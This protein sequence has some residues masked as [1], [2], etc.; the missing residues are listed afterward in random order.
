[1]LKLKNLLNYLVNLNAATFG[2]LCVETALAVSRSL[3]SFAATFGWLCVETNDK[4]LLSI[5]LLAATF[6]WLCVET[7]EPS[8]WVNAGVS[9]HLRVA[10]C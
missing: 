7:K 6:G 8:A 4:G 5:Q 3:I 2:W 9:S 10:V 1:M